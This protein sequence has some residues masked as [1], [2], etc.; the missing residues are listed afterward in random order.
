MILGI[1]DAAQYVA[2]SQVIRVD[3]QLGH[4]QLHRGNLVVVVVN[5]EVAREPGCGC[6]APQDPRAQRMKRGNPGLPRR[7][8][9]AQ[10]QIR[11]AVAHFLRSF[12]GE[13]H[14]QNRFRRHAFGDQVGH[15]I[16]DRPRFARSRA[17]ENQ[18]WA[19]LCFY[20]LA[21]FPVQFVEKFQ[22]GSVVFKKTGTGHGSRRRRSAQTGRGARG[23]ECC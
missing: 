6:F 19:L 12:V 21:L 14:R 15:A 3:P 4:G 8:A 7:D 16:G 18:Y 22:H 1:T 9:G 10:Q 11:D 2:G 17:S 5:G 13:G 20:S 23:L